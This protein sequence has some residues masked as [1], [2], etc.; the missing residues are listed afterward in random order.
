MIPLRPATVDGL[1]DAPAH[2]RRSAL[3]EASAFTRK[4]GGRRLGT[5][6]VRL[7]LRGDQLVVLLGGKIQQDAA[8]VPEAGEVTL[9]ELK[10]DGRSRLVMV[11]RPVGEESRCPGFRRASRRV[12]SR[13][14]RQ[15]ADLLSL[16]R[17]LGFFRKCPPAE[18][19]QAIDVCRASFDLLRARVISTV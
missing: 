9:H 18:A 14:K 1:V 19:D 17:F 13:Y 5:W 6:G 4:F 15:L 3:C 10:T 11:L 12:H 8:V 2:E 7:S 16:A